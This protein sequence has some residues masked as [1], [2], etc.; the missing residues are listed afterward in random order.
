MES[1][2]ARRT[3]RSLNR[4]LTILGVERRVF[5]L[6]L[7]VSGATFNF[8]GSLPGGLGMFALLYGFGLWATARDPSMLSI[9]FAAGKQRPLYDPLKRQVEA[10][11]EADAYQ[12]QRQEL[13]ASRNEFLAQ[14]KTGAR[15]RTGAGAGAGAG[16]RS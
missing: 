16:A 3:Y 15:A 8:F 2:L 5:F 11:R 12:K 9:L 10:Q 1:V 7:G 4:T 6:A 14:A 13:E